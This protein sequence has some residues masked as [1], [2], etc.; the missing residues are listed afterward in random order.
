MWTA[1]TG[2]RSGDALRSRRV[3]KTRGRDKQRDSRAL[4]TSRVV[5]PRASLNGVRAPGN[6]T[7]SPV[8]L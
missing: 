7:R 6:G 8:P 3:A 2:L 4:A 1:G 5:N